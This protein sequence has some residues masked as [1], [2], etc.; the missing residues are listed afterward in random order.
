MKL[1]GNGWSTAETTFAGTT[2]G[3][4]GASS[5]GGTYGAGPGGFTIRK[6]VAFCGGSTAITNTSGMLLFRCGDSS[7]YPAS[8]LVLLGGSPYAETSVTMPAPQNITLDNLNI[9]CNWFEF[10][11]KEGA[12]GGWG[13]FVFGD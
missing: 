7:D 2:A 5:A 11:A 6:I 8:T 4:G 3:L 9:K 12:A 13:G 1:L 10:A